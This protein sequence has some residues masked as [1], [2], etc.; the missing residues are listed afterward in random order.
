MTICTAEFLRRLFELRKMRGTVIS[1][2]CPQAK[3]KRKEI[4]Y[5]DFFMPHALFHIQLCADT[6]LDTRYV[7]E[8]NYFKIFYF[9]F[10][11][12]FRYFQVVK[13]LGSLTDRSSVP[14]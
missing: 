14:E 4:R 7:P 11:K 13:G 3:E 8:E 12:S 10:V 1:T 9:F 5:V 2:T 6:K